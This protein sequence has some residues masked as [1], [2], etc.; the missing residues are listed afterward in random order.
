MLLA[1]T[2]CPPEYRDEYRT[3]AHTKKFGAAAARRMIEEQIASD[4]RASE[5]ALTPFERQLAK[6]AAGAPLVQVRPLP[7]RGY[8]M[9]LGGVATGAI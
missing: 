5:A 8:A 2:G 7:S 9:T 1:I 3:L 4:T 6:V